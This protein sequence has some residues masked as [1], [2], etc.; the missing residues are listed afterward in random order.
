[1]DLG[2]SGP[3]GHQDQRRLSAVASAGVGCLGCSGRPV[4]AV[5][6]LCWRGQSATNDGSGAAGCGGGAGLVRS[7]DLVGC[8]FQDRNL[9]AGLRQRAASGLRGRSGV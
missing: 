5:S 7:Q 3:G 8:G 2:P 6:G 1:M 9:A 4:P